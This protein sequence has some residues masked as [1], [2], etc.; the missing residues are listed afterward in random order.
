MKNNTTKT[1]QKTI[2]INDII[3]TTDFIVDFLRQKSL[4]INKIELFLCNSFCN[5]YL[6]KLVIP[7]P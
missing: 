6:R 2:N 1:T 4:Y 3:C 5:K 7:I